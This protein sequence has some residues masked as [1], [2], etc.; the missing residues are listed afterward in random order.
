[1]KMLQKRK[2]G[3]DTMCVYFDTAEI[4]TEFA[5]ATEY[6][7]FTGAP[8]FNKAFDATRVQIEKP[9]M[10]ATSKEDGQA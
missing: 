3:F 5:F 7:L 10:A 2:T 6:S 1:M 8:A 9:W 4:C